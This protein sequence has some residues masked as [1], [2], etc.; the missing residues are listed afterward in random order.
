MSLLQ[1]L[2]RT[3]P[4]PALLWIHFLWKVRI[5]NL[6]LGLYWVSLICARCVSSHHQEASVPHHHPDDG[7]GP[8]Q[9]S[10]W[11]RRVSGLWQHIQRGDGIEPS[12]GQNQEPPV[13]SDKIASVVPSSQ[14][15]LSKVLFKKVKS[16]S[17]KIKENDLKKILY[18]QCF[19]YNI[20]VF[21]KEFLLFCSNKY[22]SYLHFFWQLE[23]NLPNYCYKV[24]LNSCIILYKTVIGS[25]CI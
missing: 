19:I 14:V 13:P 2:G 16:S 10:W 4:A 3:R 25:H 24:W 6:K 23:G 8:A 17:Y 22:L 5:H 7:A 1:S 15:L 11:L 21:T 9:G 12:Q 18:W 20:T